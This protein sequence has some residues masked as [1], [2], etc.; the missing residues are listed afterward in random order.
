L[1]LRID[2]DVFYRTIC[3]TPLG[4]SLRSCEHCFFDKYNLGL[5][6]LN[7]LCRCACV[8]D[9]ADFESFE[10]DRFESDYFTKNRII[11]PSRMPVVMR[12]R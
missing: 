12:N 8:Q 2:T 7:H 3:Y 5:D 11:V 9:F 1:V 4:G 6:S 10:Q